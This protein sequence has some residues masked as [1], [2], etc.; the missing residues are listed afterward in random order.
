M[1]LNNYTEYLISLA[2]LSISC[3]SYKRMKNKETRRR[4][5]H[6]IR[7]DIKKEGILNLKNV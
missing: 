7:D 2:N 6:E 5:Y 3:P 4:L 1:L